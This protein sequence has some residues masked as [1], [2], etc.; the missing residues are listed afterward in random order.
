MRVSVGSLLGI[1]WPHPFA[2]QDF[3]EVAGCG[4]DDMGNVLAGGHAY[5]P[6]N[7]HCHNTNHRTSKALALHLVPP[8][9]DSVAPKRSC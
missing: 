4:G 2:L 5:A 3:M 1:V 6:H 7:N 9:P 8:L